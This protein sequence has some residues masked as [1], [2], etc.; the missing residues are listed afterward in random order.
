MESL[1]VQTK[2]VC[3]ICNSD[4]TYIDKHGY[5]HW[6]NHEG[7]IYCKN[8]YGRVIDSPIRNKQNAMRQYIFLDKFLH[9]DKK[10]RTGVC[11]KCGKKIGDKYRGHRSKELTSKQTQ[12]HHQFYIT[13]CPWFSRVELCVSC[14]NKIRWQEWREKQKTIP[15]EKHH[16]SLCDSTDSVSKYWYFDK[17]NRLCRRCW[18]NT[19]YGP[20]NRERINRQ[21][22]KAEKRRKSKT[23]H[24]L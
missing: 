10:V 20:A 23:Q 2:R 11:S 18:R 6:R 3:V 9:D 24:I 4:K 5:S 8:C 17:G 12:L 1:E 13:I 7:K 15:K 16:C 14:H 21:A 19:V 22:R